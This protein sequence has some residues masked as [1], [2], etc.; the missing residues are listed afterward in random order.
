MMKASV[1]GYEFYPRGKEYGRDEPALSGKSEIEYADAGTKKLK[2]PEDE[3]EKDIEMHAAAANRAHQRNFVAN[4]ASRG[5]PVADIEE[6]HISTASCILA[7]LS[8]QLGRTLKWDPATHQV[9]G[10]AEANRLLKR[11]YRQPWVHPAS[12]SA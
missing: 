8:M 10:D 3:H 5:R 4:I 12:T 6:G 11:P 9:V 7:N 2:Y 1:N